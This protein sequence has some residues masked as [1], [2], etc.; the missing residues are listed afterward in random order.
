[1]SRRR[2]V[3]SRLDHQDPRDRDPIE[4]LGTDTTDAVT[5][6]VVR[7][8]SG[9]ARPLGF[10][11][12]AITALAVA[13]LA[14]SSTSEEDPSPPTS[15]EKEA[16][17]E[18]ADTTEAPRPSEVLIGRGPDLE[19]EQII[20]NI[21]TGEFRWIDDAFVG[22]NGETEWSIRPTII[23]TAIQQRQSLQLAYPEYYPI[24]AEGARVLAPRIDQPD[25]LLFFS[26]IDGS[27]E[28]TRV[29]LP[30]RPPVSDLVL[31][32]SRIQAAVVG[33]NAVIVIERSDQVDP[34]TLGP[35][36]GRDLVGRRPTVRSIDDE[37]QIRVSDAGDDVLNGVITIPLDELDLTAT[38]LEALRP[39]PARLEVVAADLTSGVTGAPGIVPD[40]RA[41]L[42]VAGDRFVLSWDN[43]DVAG[44]VSTSLDGRSWRPSASGVGISDVSGDGT[45]I[46][47]IEES[48]GDIARSGDGAANWRYTAEPFDKYDLTV[49]VDHLAVRELTLGQDGLD[50]GARYEID[51]VDY[52]IG[53]T[54][55]GRSFELVDTDADE[56]I[57][58]GTID[59]PATGVAYDPF[60]GGL[61][62]IDPATGE[63]IVV[64]RSRLDFA[65]A[66]G[67]SAADR[68][69]LVGFTRWD[70]GQPPEWRIEPVNE[71]F[72][73]TAT[74]VD[75]VSGG[76]H[77]LAVVTTPNG[78]TFYITEIG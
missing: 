29:D 70:G 60:D 24:D 25:H 26:S 18:T 76:G 53:I 75:F 74:G 22:E 39:S 21:R 8:G 14:L 73:P 46:V 48:S 78:Y 61:T 17:D 63:T 56:V 13:V 5:S 51:L 32:R 10:A 1:M 28:P 44:H 55:G 34:E 50:P 6:E 43:G 67:G 4:L 42:G 23:D 35:R 30:T 52:T 19:W 33:D 68:P 37:L 31:R 41:E 38:E 15:T 36:I 12:A 3:D 64:H 71:V 2:R 16:A 58:R 9:L 47:G 40:G 66:T 72:G 49:A 59:D 69:P 45:S 62:V 11:F 57:S 77:L 54:E 27:L 7:T 20:W 65:L